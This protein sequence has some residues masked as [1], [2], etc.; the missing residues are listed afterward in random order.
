M[1]NNI[2]AEFLNS[3]I[4]DLDLQALVDGEFDTDTH[5]NIMQTVK[6]YPQLLLR[7]EA[8]SDQK[9]ILKEWWQS[10]TLT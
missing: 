3:G 4:T 9:F 7:L 2:S 5:E 8:L 6:E 10:Q 1:Q